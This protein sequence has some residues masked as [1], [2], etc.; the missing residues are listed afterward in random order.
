M[1]R[2]NGIWGC[3]KYLNN[4]D[5]VKRFPSVLSPYKAT[6]IGEATYATNATAKS[7]RRIGKL[8]LILFHN[9]KFLIRILDTFWIFEI[10]GYETRQK[11]GNIVGNNEN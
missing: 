11:K 7:R 9:N 6:V 3:P 4:H 8:I 1:I 10:Y 2:C 5:K